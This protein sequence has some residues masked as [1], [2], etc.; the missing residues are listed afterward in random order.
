MAYGLDVLDLIY[1]DDNLKDV[2]TL[3]D[4]EVDLDL[5]GEKNFELRTSDFIM[6]K[7]CIW[8]VDGTE[9]GG[10]VDGYSTQSAEHEITYRGRNWRGI[11]DSKYVYKGELTQTDGTDDYGDTLTT[12]EY[13]Y[14]YSG[15]IH[16]IFN[17]LF[18]D[19]GLGSL[20]VCEKAYITADEADSYTDHTE[21]GA[22]PF[23][24]AGISVYYVMDYISAEC[25]LE[26]VFKYDIKDRKVHIYPT[27]PRNYSEMMLYNQDNASNYESEVNDQIPNHLIM[28]GE[29]TEDKTK[30][31]KIIHLFLDENYVL[32][33]YCYEKDT[34]KRSDDDYIL[35]D[36]QKKITGIREVVEPV[37]TSFNTYTNY[38]VL[39][40][41]DEAEWEEHFGQYYTR[42]PESTDETTGEIIPESYDPVVGEESA[43]TYTTL[44]D[45]YSTD[46][47][48]RIEASWPT[49]FQNYYEYTG[50]DWDPYNLEWKPVYS[51]LQE[52]EEDYENPT[53]HEIEY[54]QYEE[55]EGQP[56][57]WLTEYMDYYTHRRNDGTGEITFEQVQGIKNDKFV[58]LTKKPTDWDTLYLNYYTRK[59]DSYKSEEK[60]KKVGLTKAEQLVRDNRITTYVEQKT[61]KKIFYYTQLAEQTK[62]K[63][64][65]V[66]VKPTD[67]N[68]VYG[69]YYYRRSVGTKNPRWEYT[70]YEGNT[71]ANFVKLDGPK[72][73]YDWGKG[74]YKSYFKKTKSF[75]N[76]S[77]K[78]YK[79]KLKAVK[80]LKKRRK[81]DEYTVKK[82]GNKY[83]IDCYKNLTKKPKKWKAG[84]YYRNDSVTTPPTFKKGNCYIMDAVPKNR[85]K[86]AEKKY[87]KRVEEES[88]PNYKDYKADLWLP[89]KQKVRPEFDPDNQYVRGD[90]TYKAPAFTAGAYYKA[91]FDNYYDLVE[92]G[93]EYLREL[94]SENSQ[95]M[96]LNDDYILNI[97]DYVSG[98]DDLTGNIMLYQRVS[99]IIVKIDS[100]ASTLDYVIEE[101]VKEQLLDDISLEPDNGEEE[102]TEEEYN[103]EPSDDDYEPE[104]EE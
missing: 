47:L 45:T 9:F 8:Y 25:G 49:L 53:T 17:S 1:T 97:G 10:I 40:D 87:Y 43:E 98:Y 63:P 57:N 27:V 83:R 101:E 77:Q 16:D 52:T 70:S 60:Y 28:I 80:K 22:I 58:L 64:I 13:R 51:N 92:Q 103:S 104:D 66:N 91:I 14:E 75:K 67:W 20:F 55:K 94:V 69:N 31:Q 44:R 38:E 50:E 46:E 85:P 24:E 88:A 99:N 3:E 74:G 6:D 54:F 7:N 48:S 86:W 37:H 26:L 41:I 32:Q 33:P 23:G 61:D 78:K 89:K 72:P 21:G 35:D 11:L 71:K 81:I 56:A 2:G 73:P 82:A 19:Y 42:T 12:I 79:S 5:N 90:V 30:V 84:R 95:K 4:Y 68:K 59:I 65:K 36:S 15:Y 29:K 76:L 96:T 18:E 93:K 102:V 100:G 39:E 34:T 62:D